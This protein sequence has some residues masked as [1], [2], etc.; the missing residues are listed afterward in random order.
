MPVLNFSQIEACIYTQVLDY[1]TTYLEVYYITQ[2]LQHVHLVTCPEAIVN[3][4]FTKYTIQYFGA[5]LRTF[6]YSS[7]TFGCNF[8]L[9]FAEWL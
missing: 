8:H 3:I 5:L 9:T 4:Y 1:K 2:L 6:E 7:V